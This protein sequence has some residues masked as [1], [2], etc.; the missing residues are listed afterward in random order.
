MKNIFWGVV[1]TIFAVNVYA[2]DNSSTTTLSSA[3][4]P[5]SVLLSAQVD[6]TEKAIKESSQATYKTTNYVGGSY[7][8][9]SNDKVYAKYYF[10]YTFAPENQS[11]S[12]TLDAV[13]QYSTKTA[14]V[15]G[16]DEIPFWFW[17]YAPTSEA[18]RQ[19]NS[20]G[21]VRMDTEVMWTLTPRWKVSYYFN[22]RQTI[23]PE[24]TLEIDGQIKDSFSKTSLYHYGT[25]YYY[26]SDDAQAY[27][28]GGMIN[29][30]NTNR[31]TSVEDNVLSA[32][33][34]YIQLGKFLLN[35][36]ISNTVKFRENNQATGNNRYW[37]S[38]DLTYT[39][40][41]NMT[42]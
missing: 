27:A 4:R 14:G 3:A 31:G 32:I 33:G 11:K 9:N 1:S 2:Q 41:V 6:T 17:Y 23:V 30:W 10:G 15:L 19:I 7:A 37:Q 20:N 36:E 18:S 40:V 25:L 34:G 21:Q 42:M 22:P 26:F 5:W 16:S 39:F 8:L 29:R 12:T 38:E 35:P 24:N 13:L 28:Y